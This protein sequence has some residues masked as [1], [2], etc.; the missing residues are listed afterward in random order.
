[1]VL[2]RS[3]FLFLSCLTL[4]LPNLHAES[5]S[6]TIAPLA[7][8]SLLLDIAQLSSG[9]LIAVG[10]RGHILLSDDAGRSWRQV[11]T[12]TVTT[13]TAIAAVD[14]FLW[15]SGHDSTILFSKDGG[16]QWQRQYFDP[17]AEAPL[18][19]IYFEDVSR[20][21]AVGA[22]GLALLTQDGGRSW[23]TTTTDEQEEPHWYNITRVSERSILLTGEF[24][25]VM[26]APSIDGSWEHI[27][28]PYEGTLFGATTFSKLGL[29][30]REAIM[31]F[32]LRG[33][34]FFSQDNGESWRNLALNDTRSI[35]AAVHC[36]NSLYLLG[37]NGL[38][39]ELPS[40]SATASF[41][42]FIQHTVTER[43]GVSA[44]VCLDSALILVG[45]QGVQRISLPIGVE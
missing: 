34:V 25:R 38:F 26:R 13:L 42:E 3:T 31:V 22:Y 2:F 30:T 44:G 1:M 17:E 9:K 18:F 28:S 6:S 19:D 39:V 21:L 16:E 40:H 35:L 37:L 29:Q 11:V 15:V 20:G 4:L 10:E 23:Q 33:N 12:P 8:K 45:E 24:G 32:G 43:A 36:K 27:Q 7:E 14:D 41:E 5:S